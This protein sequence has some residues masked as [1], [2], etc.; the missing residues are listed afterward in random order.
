M[1][2]IR[3]IILLIISLF[4]YSS[5][6]QSHADLATSTPSDGSKLT[7]APTEVVLVFSTMIESQL[8]EMDALNEQGQSLASG[9]PSLNA[10]RNEL[11]IPLQEEVSGTIQVPYS[12]ISKDGHPIEGN[13]SFSVKSMDSAVTV[14]E[15]NLQ[16]MSPSFKQ[17]NSTNTTTTSPTIK[18]AKDDKNH[19]AVAVSETKDKNDEMGNQT[20]TPLSSIIKS[21][22][23]LSLLLLTGSL[24]WRFKGFKFPYLAHLQLIHLALL[25]LFTW[26]QARNFTLIFEGITWQDLFLRTE[27]G[28][29]WTAAL[30]ITV[31]GLYIVGRNRYIDVFWLTSILI[32]K[33]LNSHAIASTVPILTVGLNFVHLLFAALWVAG[34]IYLIMMWRKD[35]AQTFIPIFSKMALMSLVV[36]T[37]SGSLYAWMLAPSLSA[38]WT[39]SWGVWLIAKIVAVFAVFIIGAFI[40]R[41]LNRNGSL[42]NEKLL[43][44]DGALAIAILLAVGVLTQLSPSI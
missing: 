9:A 6:A 30:V 8:F 42:T 7:T 21:I 22:Y 35:S 13:I 40:R 3:M 26:S 10:D 14:N 24:L 17:E 2:T 31:A 28:Q 4:I 41:H 5:S 44:V 43:Y 19:A 20:A 34:L 32:A 12:V 27:V 38:L 1:K 36:L 23:L 11:T 25:V 18:T 39:T 29:F 37:V 16:G 15:N 33:S